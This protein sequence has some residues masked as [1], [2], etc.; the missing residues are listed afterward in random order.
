MGE[1]QSANCGFHNLYL[2]F[3]PS[4]YIISEK[5]KSIKG[6]ILSRVQAPMVHKELSQNNFLNFCP[7]NQ[8][9]PWKSRTFGWSCQIDLQLWL[10]L[11][12][13]NQRQRRFAPHK[14]SLQSRGSAFSHAKNGDLAP[15]KRQCVRNSGSIQPKKKTKRNRHAIAYLFFLLA[16]PAGLEPATPWLTV[17][18]SYR[19]S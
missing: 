8:K 3:L 1:L 6:A 11:L 4:V 19:L 16:P 15:A 17:R 5:R 12:G 13:S 10:P 2:A 7:K 18:C 9:S 14:F